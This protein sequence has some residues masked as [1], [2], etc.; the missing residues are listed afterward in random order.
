M[1]TVSKENSL[2]KVAPIL[3]V[4]AVLF[5]GNIREDIGNTLYWTIFTAISILTIYIGFKI[6]PS[7]NRLFIAGGFIFLSVAIGGAF[8]YL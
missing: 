3:C 4:L 6:K 2:L 8:L 1:K 7:K 5:L